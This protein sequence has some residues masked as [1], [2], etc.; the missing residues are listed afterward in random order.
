MAKARAL[1]EG[2]KK[3][4]G[5]LG[6]SFDEL[7]RF[8]EDSFDRRFYRDPNVQNQAPVYL[9]DTELIL[10]PRELERLSF[11]DLEGMPY[12]S[13][14]AD[15]TA[16]NKI[17]TGIG[18]KP[19]DQQVILHGG[20]E[21][22][23]Y[24]P[25]MWASGVGGPT[26]GMLKAAQELKAE[27]G[28][29]PLFMP[30]S[31]TPSG[32]DFAHMTGQ[33]MLS[34]ASKYMAKGPKKKL[35][36]YIESILP[37]WV[38]L[39]NPEMMKQWGTIPDKKRKLIMKDMDVNY[40]NDG[41]I[42]QAQARLAVADP[43]QLKKIDGSFQNVGLFDVDAGLNPAGG[44][45]TYGMGVRGSAKGVLDQ[46]ED[47]PTIFD[48]NARKLARGTYQ[49]KARKGEFKEGPQGPDY[50][51]TRDNQRRALEMGPFGGVIDE[52]LLRDLS[53]QGFKIDANGYVTAAA[54]AGGLLA[55][56]ASDDSEAGV[57]GVVKR[58]I[59]AGYPESTAM[60][61]ATGELPMDYASRMA[62]ATEQNFTD[63][64]YHLGNDAVIQGNNLVTYTDTG[65][66]SFKPQG[67]LSSWF[68]KDTPYISQ[69]YNK[70]LA[71]GAMPASYPV[72]INTSG[73]EKTSAMLPSLR[74]YPSKAQHW[75]EISSPKVFDSDAEEILELSNT[76][77]EF[78]I[79]EGRNMTTNML[80]MGTGLRG[81]DGLVIDN[82]IDI[83]PR[84]PKINQ[85][86]RSMGIDP[87][88]WMEE[89]S[90]T[91]GPVVAVRD[92]SKVRSSMSAAFDPDQV[93]TN[94]LLATNPAAT[95]GALLFGG[96]IGQE[97][98]GLAAH[99]QGNTDAYLTAEEK[100][101]RDGR[102]EFD[103][104][105]A[106]DIGYDRADLLPFRVN[107]ETGETEFATPEMIKGLLSAFYDYGQ[108]PKSGILNPQSLE[109]MI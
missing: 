78:P 5:L 87:K 33:A 106:D 95:L 13:T 86:L 68:S 18:G 56:T 109:E 32:G 74:S 41:S 17:L 98:Q 65:I 67:G 47:I 36:K 100:A 102:K 94:N 42:T 19:L 3:G 84:A 4:A 26:N 38:G 61:I 82:V 99:A 69:S 71:D 89:Y 63:K 30:W 7:R 64:A 103:N 101:Y 75:S 1:V 8:A 34:F 79:Y 51:S 27:Y 59:E 31:M 66:E 29:D 14:M 97:A 93:N 6:D 60:K 83:G 70:G 96:G 92:G 2:V 90:A 48:I 57:V 15:R 76:G 80:A 55:M 72:L 45:A 91:G 43:S 88:E 23:Q 20:Q 58:L 54:A 107:E 10:P 53:D 37:D 46:G 77:V 35:N 105:F 73:M 44:N 85:S 16:G 11:Q 52:K 12:L 24:D 104:F 81:A 25:D 28:V 40:R 22:M 62:R 21:F 9:P 49:S 39:D 50:L 108:L